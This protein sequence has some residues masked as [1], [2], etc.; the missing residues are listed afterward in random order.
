LKVLVIG[1]GRMGAIRAEDL[2]ENPKVS[3][4]LI[5]NR[6]P[7]HGA[8]LAQKFSAEFVPWD[9][10]GSIEADA[11][12]VAVGTAAHEQVLSQVLPHGKPV[13]CE[14]PIAATLVGHPS[15]HRVSSKIRSPAANWFS[16]TL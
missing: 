3:Q 12:V 6:N 16:A 10:L 11:F 5:T 1:S 7:D 8:A 14:K 13:L 15:R 9:L 4:V 2:S